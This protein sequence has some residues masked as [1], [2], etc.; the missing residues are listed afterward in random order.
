[1]NWKEIK[2]EPE[3]KKTVKRSI[4]IFRPLPG[5]AEGDELKLLLKLVKDYEDKFV[6]LP[7]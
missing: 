7:A 4:A 2:T 6:H 5:T 1:M 3:Y